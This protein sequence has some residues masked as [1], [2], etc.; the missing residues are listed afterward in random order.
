MHDSYFSSRYIKEKRYKEFPLER[1]KAL[2]DEMAA[3]NPTFKT[4]FVEPLLY[5][6]LKSAVEYVKS[7]DLKYYTITNGWTLKENAPWLVD[8]KTNLLRV[9]LDG[10]R[11]IHDKIRQKE[12][13]FYR[14]VDG[15][16]EVLALRKRSRVELPIVGVCFTISNYNYFN[17]V[18]FM[19]TLREEGVLSEIYVNFNHLQYTTHWEVEQTKGES[20]FFED[21]KKCSTD[22][23]SFSQLDVDVLRSQMNKVYECYDP[24]IYHYYFSPW[25][26]DE[27]LKNYYDPDYWMFPRTPCFLPWYTSQIEIDADVGIYGHCILPSL[28]NIMEQSF[29][30]VWN[31]ERAVQIRRILKKVGSF[32]ACNKCIGTLYPL[33]G[34]S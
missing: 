24:D 15:L 3:Y 31:S 23:I 34:R 30:N 27:D 22:N 14:T 32:P 16:K 21:I 8:V 5:K 1:I 7:K 28:G 26:K 4:N 17:L 10:T 18:N 12:G 29:M 19:E 25:L 6:K 2:V 20:D 13:S 33:R 9:S 11:E